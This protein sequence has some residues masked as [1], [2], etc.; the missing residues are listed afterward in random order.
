MKSLIET[1]RKCQGLKAL[2]QIVQQGRHV[3]TNPCH[4][5]NSI[6]RE[7]FIFHVASVGKTQG[8]QQIDRHVGGRNLCPLTPCCFRLSFSASLELW[9][10]ANWR[11]GLHGTLSKIVFH[12][13]RPSMESDTFNVNMHSPL[14]LST[15]SSVG[16]SPTPLVLPVMRLRLFCAMGAARRLPPGG[17]RSSQLSY[18]CHDWVEHWH[19]MQTKT[20]TRRT[21]FLRFTAFLIHKS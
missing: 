11:P 8:S 2:G 1:R 7:L 12:K 15:S 21:E 10:T 6:Q 13:S 18:H 14:M 16:P 5:C 17:W 9:D 4:F 19:K 3:V 20:R